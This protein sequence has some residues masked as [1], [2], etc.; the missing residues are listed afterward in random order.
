V[1]RSLWLHKYVKGGET[2]FC[3]LPSPPPFPLLS[4]PCTLHTCSI[5]SALIPTHSL[6]SHFHQTFTPQTPPNEKQNKKTKKQKNK[7][8]KK[9]KNKKTKKQKNKKTKK[10]KNKKTKKQKN[11]KA[12]I[13]NGNTHSRTFYTE[14]KPS[15]IEERMSG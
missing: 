5:L 12:K 13:K 6:P 8:T 2:S 9:Q 15:E 7:K 1:L 4:Q 14:T 10:Q 11:T 3:S